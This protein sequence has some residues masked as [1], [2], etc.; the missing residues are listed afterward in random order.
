MDS[1]IPLLPPLQ[2]DLLLATKTKSKELYPR[3]SSLAEKNLEKSY[4]ASIKALGRMF[5]QSCIFSS[6]TMEIV[7]L[8]AN[9]LHLHDNPHSPTD[10]RHTDKHLRLVMTLI[11]L[12]CPRQN[13]TPN[14]DR[15][16]LDI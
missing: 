4:G 2:H 12:C 15:C 7:Q 8:K 5:S 3:V 10:Y 11:A 9:R 1:W 14:I 6:V 13:R 16:M